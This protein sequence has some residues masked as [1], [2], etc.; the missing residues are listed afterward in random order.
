MHAGLI[1]F[2]LNTVRM[3]MAVM[4]FSNRGRNDH[5]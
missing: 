4:D 3:G 1:A 2:N 5:H